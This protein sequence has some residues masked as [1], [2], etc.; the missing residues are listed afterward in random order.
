MIFNFYTFVALLC[1]IAVLTIMQM[2]HPT[3]EEM[4]LLKNILIFFSGCSPRDQ[5]PRAGSQ[6]DRGNLRP[7]F[8]HLNHHQRTI[9]TI[10]SAILDI[11][12]GFHATGIRPESFRN[13]HESYRL[14]VVFMFSRLVYINPAFIADQ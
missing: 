2:N 6:V 13:P 9:P 10:H 14:G 1:T 4:C 3:W 12:N 8:R 5:V 11:Y 7:V